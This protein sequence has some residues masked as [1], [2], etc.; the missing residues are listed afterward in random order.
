MPCRFDEMIG[1][2]E[3]AEIT[4]RSADNVAKR[5]ARVLPGR[6]RHCDAYTLK[7]L[8]RELRDFNITTGE[9]KED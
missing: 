2:I 3:D 5:L 6:L 1:A 4:L 8:K 9:W 7:R